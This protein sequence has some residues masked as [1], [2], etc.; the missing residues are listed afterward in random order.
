MGP[1]LRRAFGPYERQVS[2][3]YRRMF[4]DLD[5]LVASIR[6]G[7]EIPATVLEVGC[8]DGLVTERLALAFPNSA[9]TGIDICAHPGRLYRGDRTRARFMRSSTEE[10]GSSEAARYQLVIVADVL[11]HVPHHD[12]QRFLAGATRLMADGG[13]L[14]LKDWVREST[15]A[16]LMGYLSDRVITGDR[17]RYPRED[18]LRSLARAI[19]GTGAVYSE[20]RVAPWHCNLTLVIKSK[21]HR[22]TR[23]NDID[24]L[25]SKAARGLPPT[26]LPGG[27]DG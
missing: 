26:A 9:L 2:E 13:T 18:E 11:H 21:P 19:F 4:V 12:W 16:Y 17:I 3:L 15:P 22:D 25:P 7:I 14:V 10:L 1:L 23:I 27:R 24:P 6:V 8:G 20:F 5:A